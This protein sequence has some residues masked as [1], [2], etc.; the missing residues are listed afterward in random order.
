YI[1]ERLGKSNRFSIVIELCPSNRHPFQDKAVFTELPDD[2][3][4][5]VL[6]ANPDRMTRRENEIDS[7]L[8]GLRGNILRWTNVRASKDVV[9]EQVKTGRYAVSEIG[10]YGQME[11]AIDRTFATSPDDAHLKASKYMVSECFTR[12]GIFT[13]ITV[14]RVLPTPHGKTEHDGIKA[15]L[16]R[17][18]RFLE[19]MIPPHVLTLYLKANEV[20]AYKDEF[21]TLMRDTLVKIPTKAMV[22]TVSMD[23]AAR[24]TETFEHFSKINEE[25]GHM[26]MSF[27]WPDAALLPVADAL[28]I[29][30]SSVDFNLIAADDMLEEQRCRSTTIQNLPI[31]KLVIRIPCS[32][33]LNDVIK[34]TLQAAKNYLRSCGTRFQGEPLLSIP[35]KLKKPP[36]RMLD[37]AHIEQ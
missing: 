27:L 13:A 35:D 25:A 8:K 6:T 5:I 28:H 15:S 21:S 34:S 18:Q 16:L 37:K 7:I 3:S 4:M 24:G 2:V 29:P 22:L 23:R 31:V 30:P 20:S 12:H 19:A 9:S 32:P 10:K 14:C 1:T 26:F 11:R 17:Q 36:D 33:S